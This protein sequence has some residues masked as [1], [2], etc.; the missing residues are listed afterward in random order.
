[1]IIRR[2]G[3]G[4]RNADQDHM[5]QRTGPDS[6]PTTA[7][8]GRA[9]KP[10]LLRLLELLSPVDRR[11]LAQLWA[12][13]S[14]EPAALLTLMTDPARMTEQWA[15]LSEPEQAVLMRLLQD[16]GAVPVGV[17]QR[18][19]GGVREPGAFEH[20]RAYVQALSGPATPTERLYS[21]G[22]IFKAHDERGAIYRIPNDLLPA[23]QAVLGDVPPRD[24]RLHAPPAA[25]EAAPAVAPAAPAEEIVTLLLT[26]GYHG[27]L[28]ALDDGALNKAS[29][30]K[31]IRQLPASPDP[32]TIRREADWPLIALLRTAAVGADLLRRTG[33][34]ELR[35]TTHALAWL[36]APQAQRTRALLDGWCGSAL[37]DLTVLCG[38]RWQGG[39]PYTLNRAAT[40]RGL[41]ALLGTL[42][43]ATWLDLDA[44]VAAIHRVEP[45]FQRRD[46]RYDSWLLYDGRD[47]LVSG[48]QDW[49]LV[50]GALIR[51][52]LCGSL[53][54]LGLA[55]CSADR[56]VRLTA[57]GAHLLADP[58]VA[59]PEP[60]EPP[61]TPL[62]VQATFD[63]LCP[64]GASCYDRFQLSRVAELHQRGAVSVYKL[65]RAALLA[66]AERGIDADDV[67]AFLA[68]ASAG[69]LPPAV[70]Y[71]LR[72][73]G[74]QSAQ[75]R[76]EH[77][78]LLHTADPVV[79]ARLRAAR[80]FELGAI[81][82]LTPTLL[83]VPDGAAD[84]LAE[85]LRRA[86]FG[87]RDERIDPALPIDERDLCA[88]VTAACVSA[89]VSAELDL[90]C[91]ISPTMLQ[92][93]LKLVPLRQAQQAQ[94]TAEQVAQ[95]LLRQSGAQG[96][97]DR[98]AV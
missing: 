35:P 42:P 3:R 50:E 89:R 73:W 17:L 64:P 81:E 47:R 26:L 15:R 28:R 65:T 98:E 93:L 2:D 18:E 75:V 38:L 29:L 49:P 94:Q 69:P 1:M 5:M 24:R 87:V 67:I 9:R 79:M 23:L 76:L 92:R 82:P 27:E 95:R 46:G 86:G 11:V 43:A 41:L 78:V 25:I 10:E 96:G 4:L 48:W 71:T 51:A 22:L 54:W 31:L 68:D 33:D 53:S 74:G 16:R 7:E 39:A 19:F 72:E 44:I 90:A 63:V 34:G 40:R 70:A 52:V 6:R 58:A 66:A 14:P 84:E 61:T 37:D 36:R 32:R 13:P 8:P 77:A 55:E 56:Y 20:P 12:A 85:R 21:M 57:L 83:R 62:I 30:V 91:D 59:P 88:L 97:N 45:D 60:P 80:S